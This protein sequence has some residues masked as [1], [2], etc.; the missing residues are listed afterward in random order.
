[1]TVTA[2]SS[3]LLMSVPTSPSPSVPTSSGR[4]GLSS[5]AAAGVAAALSAAATC[6]VL[7]SFLY[8]RRCGRREAMARVDP[9]V[10]ACYMCLSSRLHD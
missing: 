5:G 10:G 6:L 3:T 1:M 7:A 2:A 4:H 8:L 9:F